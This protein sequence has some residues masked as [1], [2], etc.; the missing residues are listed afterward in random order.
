MDSVICP[1]KDDRKASSS[2]A[3]YYNVTWLVQVAI[4]AGKQTIFESTIHTASTASGFLRR[5]Q[6]HGSSWVAC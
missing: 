2:F 5:A 6:W 4:G 3:G 1:M